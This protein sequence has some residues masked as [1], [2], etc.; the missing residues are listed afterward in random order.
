MIRFTFLMTLGL[1]VW[2]VACST[3]SAKE[4]QGG[5]QVPASPAVDPAVAA[6][7]RA[8]A[9][10]AKAMREWQA[11][12]SDSRWDL[13]VVV[14]GTGRPAVVESDVLTFEHGTVSSDVLHKAGYER[15]GFSLYPPTER[16]IAWEAMQRKTEKGVEETAIWRA[17]VT[18]ETMQGTLTKQRTDGADNRVQQFSFTGRLMTAPATPIEE[19]PG[20]EATPGEHRA[21]PAIPSAS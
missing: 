9:A 16:S 20:Q 14:S 7:E 1:G 5:V 19:A 12:L 3:G 6:A 8:R 17:E 11:K 15:A 13:E 2:L 10:Q 21:V 18:G 4:R